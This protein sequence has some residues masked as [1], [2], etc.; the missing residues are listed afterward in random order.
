MLQGI[1]FYSR[2]PLDNAVRQMNR[3][4][5]GRCVSKPILHNTQVNNDDASVYFFH[6]MTLIDIEYS[7]LK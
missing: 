3:I 5:A 7:I 2:L 4:Y 6:Y 1:Y